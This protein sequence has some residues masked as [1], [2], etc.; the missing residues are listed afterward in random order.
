MKITE[1]PEEI[2]ASWISRKLSRAVKWTETRSEHMSSS[3]HGRDQ[4]D[5]VKVGAKRDGT[6]TGLECTAIADFG[7]FYTILTPFI[8]SFTGLRDLRL[9]QDPEP[10][11]HRQGRRSPTRCARTPPAARAGPRPRT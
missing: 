4:I 11:V 8:P 6:I 2:L 3:I 10:E 1:Y 7:A 9:L 5:Y